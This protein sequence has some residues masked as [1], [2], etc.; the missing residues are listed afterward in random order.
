M[1]LLIRGKKMMLEQNKVQNRMT[2]E[3][4]RNMCLDMKVTKINNI[5]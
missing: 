2:D 3:F 1:D 5:Q 4:T